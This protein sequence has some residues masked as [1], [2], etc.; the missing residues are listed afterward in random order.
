MKSFSI[1]PTEENAFELLMSNSL[2][3][4][5]SVFRFLKLIDAAEGP[6]SIALNG[7]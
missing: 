1:L 7:E 2:G 5:Q 6:C 3:R 4:N